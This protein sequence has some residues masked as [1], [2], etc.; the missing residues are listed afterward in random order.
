MSLNWETLG[1]LKTLKR[2]IDLPLLYGSQKKVKAKM[3]KTWTREP[4]QLCWR[5]MLHLMRSIETRNAPG[6]RSGSSPGSWAE[7]WTGHTIQWTSSL[8]SSAGP[9]EVWH[10]SAAAATAVPIHAVPRL[11][12]IG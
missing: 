9:E 2:K 5:M 8:L 4:E 3:S 10:A 11:N 6:R 1:I 12:S 7:N